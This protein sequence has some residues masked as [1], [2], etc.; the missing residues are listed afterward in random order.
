MSWIMLVINRHYVQCAVDA[1]CASFVA[2]AY[3][4]A[5]GHISHV[6]CVC[7]NSILQYGPAGRGTPQYSILVSSPFQ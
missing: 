5:C 3:V 7:R 1:W 4:R 2:C 6:L